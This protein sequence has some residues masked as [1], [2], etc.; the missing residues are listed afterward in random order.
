LEN[1]IKQGHILL[2]CYIIARGICKSFIKYKQ[3]NNS[4]L[5]I[6]ESQKPKPKTFHFSLSDVYTKEDELHST[7]TRNISLEPQV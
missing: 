2:K 4:A 5:Y 7:H 6:R 1:I 3:V